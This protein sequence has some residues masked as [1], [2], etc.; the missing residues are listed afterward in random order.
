MS[1]TAPTP[2]RE[3]GRIGAVCAPTGP[4][5]P[6]SWRKRARRI[7]GANNKKTRPG[8]GHVRRGR[9]DEEKGA[10]PGPAHLILRGDGAAPVGATAVAAARRWAGAR[11][12]SAPPERT[13]ARFR[14][15]GGPQIRC[16]W[17]C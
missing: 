17:I 13:R 6:E 3:K 15:E 9:H 5:A 16:G 8:P 1:L 2:Q 4:G 12:A 11:A 10:A 7:C 14:S